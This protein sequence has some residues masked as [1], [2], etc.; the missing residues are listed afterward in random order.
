MANESL[1]RL[2]D[3]LIQTK[4][5]TGLNINTDSLDKLRTSVNQMIDV[6]NQTRPVG[7]NASA[8]NISGTTC[9]SFVNTKYTKPTVSLGELEEHVNKMPIE[10]C[11]LVVASVCSCVNRTFLSPCDCENRI[12]CLCHS[13]DMCDCQGNTTS[14]PCNGQGCDC[15]HRGW[16]KCDCDDRGCTCNGQT[17]CSCNNRTICNCVENIGPSCNG[18]TNQPTCPCNGRCSCNTEKRFT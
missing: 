14:C 15:N 1:K 8:G 11:S 17:T 10:A 13:R 3:T 16:H 2:K 6:M 9:G 4:K 18:R 7:P 5:Y 12:S